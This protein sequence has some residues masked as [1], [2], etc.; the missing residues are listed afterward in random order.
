[1]TIIK[2]ISLLVLLFGTVFSGIL[3]KFLNNLDK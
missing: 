3:L 2:I 1:M